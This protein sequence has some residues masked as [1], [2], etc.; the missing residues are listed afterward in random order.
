[1]LNRN[2]VL[3]PV[4]VSLIASSGCATLTGLIPGI[5][6]EPSPSGE[7]VQMLYAKA[8]R[9]M[10][11]DPIKELRIN[12]SEKVWIVN[13]N[14]GTN[15][16]RPVDALTYDAITDVLRSKGI[17]DVVARDDDMIRSLYVEYTESGKLAARSDSLARDGKIQPA[18]V[19]LTYRV[20]RLNTKQPGLII[21]GVRFI[22]AGIIGLFADAQPNMT[23]GIRL[24]IHVDAIDV[25]SGTVRASRIVEHLEPQPDGMAAD[26]LFQAYTK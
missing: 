15:S 8:V 16:D 13:K 3:V 12:P 23:D 9:A 19:I 11:P 20:I 25:K 4:L 14:G 18:D 5:G 22:L 17:A 2:F 24:A 6:G 26:Y 10:M 7:E 21:L 1:M